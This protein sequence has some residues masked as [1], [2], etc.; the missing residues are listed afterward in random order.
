M[1]LALVVLPRSL[2]RR[3]RDLSGCFSLPSE[4][5]GRQVAQ[6]RVR[7]LGVVVDP[8]CFNSV[9]RIGEGK[10]AA[11]IEAL[12]S[13]A[14]VEGLDERIIRG[15]PGLEKSSS[16]PFRY[17][18]WSSSRPANSGPLSTRMVFGLPRSTMRRSRTSTTLKALKVAL[19]TVASP[20][21]E[22]QSTTVRSRK[23]RPSNSASDMKSIAQTSF[24]E[25]ICGRPAR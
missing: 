14:G 2:A 21:R 16:T 9:P 13:D 8:P 19:G 5:L 24:G 4:G 12:G 18:H 20:S 6:G 1:V 23:G 3:L 10:E 22:Q 11:G 25:M 15:V 7:P 17:A